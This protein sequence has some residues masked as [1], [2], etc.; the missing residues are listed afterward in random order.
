MVPGDEAKKGRDFFPPQSH[1]KKTATQLA[2]YLT[3]FSCF[4][5]D[6]SLCALLRIAVS[7]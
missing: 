7:L 1:V 2:E 4:S 5:S 3:G 6:P